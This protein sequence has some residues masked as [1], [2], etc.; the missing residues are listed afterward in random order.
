MQDVSQRLDKLSPKQRKLFELML[1]QKRRREAQSQR[2]PRREPA[3]SEPLSFA[4]QRLWF[5][6]RLAPGNPYYNMPRAIRFRGALDP[7]ALGRALD[8]IVRRHEA[9]RT[10]FTTVD[11]EPV[12]Q[13]REPFSLGLPRL[14]LS[15]LGAEAAQRQAEELGAT[16]MRLPFDL[17]TGP[18]L[19]C[20][21]VV[22]GE[23]EHVLF[24]SIHHIVSDGWSQMVLA[25]EVA[26]LYQ[27][28]VEQRPSPLPDLPIQYADF[29]VWQR[30]WLDEAL[31]EAELE[32]WVRH[33]AAAPPLLELP[34]DHP[35]PAVQS[36]AGAHRYFTLDPDLSRRLHQLS[37]AENCSLYMTLAA[38]FRTLVMRLTG[39]TDLVLGSPIANRQRRELEDLIGFFVNML[40]MR[41]DLSGDPTYRE[42]LHRVEEVTLAAYENQD[43]PFERLVEALKPERDLSTT[44]VFQVMFNL[45]NFPHTAHQLPDLEI[46]PWQMGTGT[47]KYDLSLYFFG[48]AERLAGFFEYST[49]LFD[50][51]TI[52]R[53]LVYLETLLGAVVEN[54]DR[55]LSELP[56]MPAAERHQLLLEGQP[57]AA[58]LDTAGGLPGWFE[59]QARR[60]SAATA[61]EAADRTWSYGELAQRVGELARAL[62]RRSDGGRGWRCCSIAE[63]TWWRRCWQCCVPAPPTCPSIPTTLGSASPS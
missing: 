62:R 36:L 32:Y 5:L 41:T 16:A 15:G 9:L 12:Q 4:Q 38:A 34:A 8:E 44:P 18:L 48:N 43:L 39:R 25:R 31:L 59:A 30:G 46:D 27:A 47:S 6:D 28:M 17:E 3:P 20:L 21:L 45:L 2:I 49:D 26:E 10:V 23:R 60:T 42:L 63:P 22:L 55:R 24:L 37:E 52:E 50:A 1:L 58:R 19:R 33:L 61:L 56:L 35:R 14:D 7:A 53:M 51:A 57:P 54:P 29:A 40:V 13:V 11:D